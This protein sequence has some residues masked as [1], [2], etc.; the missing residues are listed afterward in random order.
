[1]ESV[2]QMESKDR[3]KY[4][5]AWEWTAGVFSHLLR[6]ATAGLSSYI[7]R[8]ERQVRTTVTFFLT[9]GTTR[10]YVVLGPLYGIVY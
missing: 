7:R 9:S 1:M 6:S 4:M 3:M 2:N 10:G 8:L 5:F